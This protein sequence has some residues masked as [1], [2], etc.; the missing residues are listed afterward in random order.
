VARGLQIRSRETTKQDHFVN[1]QTRNDTYTTDTES[2]INQ[3]MDYFIPED[4]VS[5]DGV[6]HKR[7]RQQTLEPLHKP[8]MMNSRNRKYWRFWKSSTLAKHPAK[9]V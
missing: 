8:M 2:T 6:H 7:I 4:S 5:S 9:M 3:L 1:S